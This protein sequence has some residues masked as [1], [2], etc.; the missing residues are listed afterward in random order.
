MPRQDNNEWLNQHNMFNRRQDEIRTKMGAT[1]NEAEALD[2]IKSAQLKGSPNPFVAQIQDVQVNRQISDEEVDRRA[3]FDMFSPTFNFRYIVRSFRRELTRAHRYKRPL[4]VC[5]VIVDGLQQIL[6][7]SGHLALDTALMSAAET[8]IRCCRADVDMVG[9]YG[10]DRFMLVLP[11]TP[12]TGAAV[13]A[14]RIRKKFSNIEI[15]HQWYK[16]HITSSIGIS[17]YPGHGGDVEALIAQADLAA[18]N[19]QERGGN[20]VCYAPETPDGV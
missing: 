14:E 10:E 19:A 2:L 17:Y 7:D 20:S 1:I 5:I 12:G 15:P 6:A 13:L 11:E 3:F 18:E 4:S 9:R 8:L 16:L